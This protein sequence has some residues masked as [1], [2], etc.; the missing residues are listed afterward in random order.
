MH[1]L[2]DADDTLWEDI[3]YYRET[4]H[5][6]SKIL[7]AYHDS[8]QEI[9][10][11]SLST[12]LTQQQSSD[13]E[14]YGLGPKSFFI[15]LTKVFDKLIKEIGLEAYR[16]QLNNEFN[17]IENDFYQKPLLLIERVEETL[18]ELCKKSY[19]LYLYTQGDIEH[20]QYKIQ[21]SNIGHYF[22]DHFIIRDKNVTNLRDILQKNKIP[23]TSAVVIGNSIRSDINPAKHLG[24]KT[25]YLKRPYTWER[26]NQTIDHVGFKTHIVKYFHEI[27][28]IL[29][30]MNVNSNWEYI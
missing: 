10:V 9:F 8:Q 6:I 4:V 17:K 24:L 26:E 7:M 19:K 11:N 13:I 25:I 23:P 20:Q 2:I 5:N 16:L 14:H 21:C 3:I 22:Q 18:S 12:Y 27:I 15:S 1:L 29:E 30:N 28:S